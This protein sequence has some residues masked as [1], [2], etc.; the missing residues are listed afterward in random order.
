MFYKGERRELYTRYCNHYPVAASQNLTNKLEGSVGID[1]F[2]PHSRFWF[3]RGLCCECM[4]GGASLHYTPLCVIWG[5]FSTQGSFLLKGVFYSGRFF[6]QGGFY[7][8]FFS[9]QGFFTQGSCLFRVVSTQG[10][11]FTQGVFYSV[12]FCCVALY[13]AGFVLGGRAIG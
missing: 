13:M 1:G 7:P 6:T 8:G 11:F 4:F 10:R 5:D 3:G 9:L 12:V 2:L